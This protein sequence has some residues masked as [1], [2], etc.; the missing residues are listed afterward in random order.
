MI[1]LIMKNEKKVTILNLFEDF[2][3]YLN[4][5][6]TLARL[7][8]AVMNVDLGIWQFHARKIIQNWDISAKDFLYSVSF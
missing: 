1:V 7:S 3:G 4:L 5:C 2:R 6:N 8:F